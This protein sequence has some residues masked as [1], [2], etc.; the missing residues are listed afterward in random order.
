MTRAKRPLHVMVGCFLMASVVLL[1]AQMP[2]VPPATSPDRA[3]ELVSLM[4]A[5]KLDAF[6][7]RDA[8]QPG[9]FVAALRVADVQLLAVSAAYS[10]PNDV[11]YALY[12]K[13][14]MS[15]YQNLISG[16]LA[17]DRFFVEDAQLNGLVANPGKDPQH[18]SVTT[19]D[20]DKTTFD[21][22]PLDKKK[23]KQA[24]MTPEDYVKA[25]S[26]ADARYAKLLDVL[27][28][29]LKSSP[30]PILDAPSAL[31]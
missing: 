31:R 10:R 27:L 9:R 6:A 19:G 15:A 14:Y 8:M 5:K 29:A 16:A 22:V 7:A 4:K 24:K 18:D 1:A 13:D 12:T 11:E 25:F 26:D 3:K 20:E 2:E 28:V 21:G 17:S 30:Q 23:K